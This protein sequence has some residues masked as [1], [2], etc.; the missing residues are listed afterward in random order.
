MVNG[1]EGEAQRFYLALFIGPLVVLTLLARTLRP[2]LM[3]FVGLAVGIPAILSVYADGVIAT[4]LRLTEHSGAFNHDMPFSLFDVDCADVAASHFGESPRRMYVDASGHSLYASCR[5]LWV[6]G[7]KQGGWGIE[8]FPETTSARQKT[9]LERNVIGTS[10]P[11]TCWN[12]HPS[13]AVCNDLKARG[14]CAHG[15]GYFVECTLPLE[16]PAAR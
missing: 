12:N 14:L 13:D 3:P 10:A 16:T 2:A 1:S 6:P 5:S 11:A 15:S 7:Q 8:I 9:A 4:S